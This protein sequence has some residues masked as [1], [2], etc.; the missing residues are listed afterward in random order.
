MGTFNLP[1]KSR[2]IVKLQ[3]I[4]FVVDACKSEFSLIVLHVFFLSSGFV[5]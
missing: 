5:S 2:G 1:V 4:L 3:M